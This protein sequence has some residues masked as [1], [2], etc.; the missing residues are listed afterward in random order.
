MDFWMV[1]SVALAVLWTQAN[2]IYCAGL[3]SLRA[4]ARAR[5]DALVALDSCLLSCLE[6]T[7]A[8][9]KEEFVRWRAL[10]ERTILPESASGVLE[11]YRQQRPHVPPEAAAGFPVLELRCR[12]AARCYAEAAALYNSRIPLIFGWPLSKWMGFVPV[13]APPGDGAVWNGV[14]P[15]KTL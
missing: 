10:L 15:G 8:D 4:E 1:L 13:Q 12:Q 9:S 7:G 3:H 5:W 2:V 6:A 14:P 11:F